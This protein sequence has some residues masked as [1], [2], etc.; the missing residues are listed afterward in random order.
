MCSFYYIKWRHLLNLLVLDN[1]ELKLK[2]NG[3]LT[4]I[5][6]C[7]ASDDLNLVDCAV[8]EVLQEIDYHYRSF[9]SVQELKSV[10]LS[11]HSN[12]CH[13]RFL[14]ELSVNGSVALK[15]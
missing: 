9:K 5:L 4:L 13:K 15:M 6:T 3:L 12:N 10:I 7:A 1:A 11:Q 14:M 8:L 2:H